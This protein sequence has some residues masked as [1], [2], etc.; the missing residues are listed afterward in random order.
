MEYFISSNTSLCFNQ[1]KTVYNTKATWNWLL[2]VFTLI[3][4]Y[5]VIYCENTQ[6]K[7][8]RF[9]GSLMMCKKIN[10]TRLANF[11]SQN[12]SKKKQWTERKA[13]TYITSKRIIET[14]HSLKDGHQY[15]SNPN[16]SDQKYCSFGMQFERQDIPRISASIISFDLFWPAI[17]R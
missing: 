4:S 2:N 17:R 6:L 15:C 10:Y 3:L 1:L 9:R 5:L 14:Q 8:P 11:L 12:V 7:E 16:L 13:L